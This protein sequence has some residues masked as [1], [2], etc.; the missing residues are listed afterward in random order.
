MTTLQPLP[1]AVPWRSWPPIRTGAR[2]LRIELRR[3]AMVWLSPLAI[4][5]F[6]AVTLEKVLRLPP[7]WDERASTMQTYMALLVAPLVGCAA[8]TGS[9]ASVPH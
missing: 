5:L 6:L 2:L 8:W 7:M 3:S 1:A 4:A 9:R